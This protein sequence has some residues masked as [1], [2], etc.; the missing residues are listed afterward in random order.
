MSPTVSPL[1]LI[2]SEASEPKVTSPVAPRVVKSPAAGVEP[3]TIPSKVPASISAVSAANESIL[4]VPSMKRSWNSCE[5]EPKS[6]VSS[7][8]GVMSPTVSPLKLI[9]SE[10]S[11]PKVTSPLAPRVVNAPAAGVPPPMATPSAVPESISTLV[12]I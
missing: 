6:F 12:R 8:F 4:A 9:A 5:T 1:K 11:E 2:A 10:A 7:T 3:P